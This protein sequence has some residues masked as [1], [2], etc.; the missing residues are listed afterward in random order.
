[1]NNPRTTA[2]LSAVAVVLLSFSIFGGGERPSSALATLQYVLLGLALVG[3]VGS[4]IKM[5]RGA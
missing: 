2:I 4:L 3:L 5:N 1:M